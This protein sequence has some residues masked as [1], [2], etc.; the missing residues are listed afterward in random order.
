MWMKNFGVFSC[1]R[2]GESVVD[3]LNRLQ[4]AKYSEGLVKG[5][6]YQDNPG[7][8]RTVPLYTFVPQVRLFFL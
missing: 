1:E 4:G 8:I 7:Y 2:V 6:H 5:A 3:V